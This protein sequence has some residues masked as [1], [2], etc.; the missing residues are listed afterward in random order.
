MVDEKKLKLDIDNEIERLK[1]ILEHPKLY[2]IDYL[3][4]VK[5][6]IDAIYV[7]KR[8]DLKSE[9]EFEKISDKWPVLIDII[10]KCEKLC[11]KNVLSD[12][13]INQAEKII[14]KLESEASTEQIALVQKK[15]DQFESHLLANN[16]HLVLKF[17]SNQNQNVILIVD[18]G[19]SSIYIDLLKQMFVF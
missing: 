10:E 1:L 6:T 13:L 16:S 12:E 18:Q 7:Q 19:F 15:I 14:K 11:L 17:K 5:T 2:V 9:K 8:I 4:D 3:S